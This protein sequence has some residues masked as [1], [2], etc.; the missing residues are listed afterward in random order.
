MGRAAKPIKI[1]RV[2]AQADRR[3]ITALAR[4]LDVLRC[5]GSGEQWLANQEIARRTGL[6]KA[7]VSRLT[8]TLTSLGYLDRSP[9]REM[10]G[11]GLGFRVLSQF[12]LGRIA[13]PFMQAMADQA[14]G[15][16]S[17]GVRH[18][19]T[20]VYVAH[21]RS[22]SPLTLGLDVGARMPLADSAMGRAILLS[23]PEPARGQALAQL[24]EES[25]KGWEALRSGLAVAQRDFARLGF[26]ASS[27]ESSIAVVA[28]P[29]H[30]G[31][32][33]EPLALNCGGPAS[34]ISRNRLMA[35]IGPA[36]IETAAAIGRAI[37]SDN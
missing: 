31:D 9:E 21:C 33:R 16:V 11:L 23:L 10:Y 3:F 32:G 22:P 25:P 30:V 14:Q 19:T 15:A 7:T 24:Q 13:R 27:P 37:R 29:L 20:V 8:F 4:G 12:D 2:D 28:V 5:F 34:T 26:V 6:P 36:L 35:E 1:E 17:L 18:G